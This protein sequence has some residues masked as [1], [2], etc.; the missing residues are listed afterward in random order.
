MM[1]HIKNVEII[2]KNKAIKRAAEVRR[3]KAIRQCNKT[4]AKAHKK[5]YI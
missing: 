1:H 2:A 4:Y 5:V 3:M